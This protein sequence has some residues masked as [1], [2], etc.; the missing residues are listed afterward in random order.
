MEYSLMVI[1][2]L[3]ALGYRYYQREISPQLNARN[4]W[5]RLEFAHPVSSLRDKWPE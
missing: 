5:V 2:A 3:W 1:G 4:W